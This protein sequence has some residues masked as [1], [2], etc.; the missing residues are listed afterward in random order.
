MRLGVGEH[1]GTAAVQGEALIYRRLLITFYWRLLITFSD[2]CVFA[3][4]AA[5]QGEET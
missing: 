3:G 4:A 2:R 5:V 1:A